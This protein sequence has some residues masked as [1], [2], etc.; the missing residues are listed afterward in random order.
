MIYPTREAVEFMAAAVQPSLCAT[1]AHPWA[2]QQV[3]IGVIVERRCSHAFCDGALDVL[4]RVL[5]PIEGK[6]SI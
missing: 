6:D 2:K 1:Y 3:S 4:D 5:L